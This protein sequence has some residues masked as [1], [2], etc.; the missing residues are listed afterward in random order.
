MN[1]GQL[2]AWW[3]GRG[4]MRPKAGGNWGTASR[5]GLASA[6]ARRSCSPTGR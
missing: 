5:P 6:P 2:G 4:L 3:I 1:L